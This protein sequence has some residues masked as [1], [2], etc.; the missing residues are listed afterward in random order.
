MFNI[1]FDRRDSDGHHAEHLI[2][3]IARTI[4]RSFSSDPLI[5]WLRPNAVPWIQQESDT[6]RWQYRRIQRTMLEGNVF[7]SGSVKKM[8]TQ[9]PEKSPKRDSKIIDTAFAALQDKGSSLNLN[10]EIDS[11]DVGAV[12]FL[13]S[14]E[15]TA[16][17]VSRLWLACK[18]WFLDHLVPAHDN[19]ASEKVLHNTPMY[20]FDSNSNSACR[21]TA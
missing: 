11:D 8:A 12:V 4:H 18:L 16:W 9:H 10:N 13:F 21:A 20:S 3:A 2:P 1:S 7:I 19:G 17:T 15:Q 14:P 6:C 5:Q